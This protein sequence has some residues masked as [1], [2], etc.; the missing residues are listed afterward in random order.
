[1]G[2]PD[3]QQFLALARI[4]NRIVGGHYERMLMLVMDRALAGKALIISGE[5]ALLIR[6]PCYTHMLYEIADKYPGKKPT[7]LFETD[8]HRKF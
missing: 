2:D 5:K 1:M 4:H 6:T 3:D 8:F 7:H